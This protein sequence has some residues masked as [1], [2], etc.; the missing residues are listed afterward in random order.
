MRKLLSR[1]WSIFITASLLFALSQFY[2]ATNA[3]I[4][5]DLVEDLRLDTEGLGLISAAFF[6]AFALIQIPLGI[7]LDRVGPRRT[8]SVLS[9]V[10][11]CG[12]LV[13]SWSDS[14]AGGLV[15]RILMGIGMS[16]NLMGTLKLLTLWFESASF[17]TL[18]GIVLAIGTMGNVAA[19]TPLVLLVRWC[20]W[21]WALSIIAGINLVLVVIFYRVVRDRPRG[22]TQVSLPTETYD[23]LRET[24][25]GMRGL[26]KMREYWII[27][28]AAFFRSG[29]F[30]AFQALWAG[31]Y[32]MGVLGLDALD[33]GN[34]LF[35]INVGMVLGSLGWGALSDRI[36]KT[37]KWVVLSVV[38]MLAVCLFLTAILPPGTGYPILALLFFSIGFFGGGGIVVFAHIK[39]L[40]PIELAGTAMTGVNFFTMIG[41]ALFLQGLGAFMQRLYPNASQGPEAFKS[42]F[43][44]CS[45]CLALGAF[46]YLLTRDSRAK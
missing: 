13:F 1:R 29:V 19:T 3:V 42:A 11:V 8:M 2:R 20:G 31:P 33:A 39:D 30:A 46:V 10:A 21:R 15:G 26:L 6:Y 34:L 32:L 14:L 36:L 37:R 4:A 5:P 25:S 45:V 16:C 7:V 38:L 18:S 24:L 44:F 17:A 22:E 41:A 43:I 28:C 27:S 9:L 23:P 35:L 12:A 40:T